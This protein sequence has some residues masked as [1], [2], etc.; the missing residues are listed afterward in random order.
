LLRQG[1]DTAVALPSAGSSGPAWPLQQGLRHFS[2]FGSL[3]ASKPAPLGF[4]KHIIK[5]SLLTG[6][7]TKVQP[8]PKFLQSLFS[9][10]LPEREFLHRQHLKT[11]GGWK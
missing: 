8:G 3:R 9:T 10:A 7:P 2:R 6:F 5:T 1:H 4:E 11:G